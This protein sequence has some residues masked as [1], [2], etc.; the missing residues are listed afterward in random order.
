MSFIDV[1]NE[2]PDVAVGPKREE[3][4]DHRHS[5]IAVM[6]CAEGA[7]AALYMNRVRWS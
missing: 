6:S 7:S 3:V 5:R 1:F 2:G 4:P